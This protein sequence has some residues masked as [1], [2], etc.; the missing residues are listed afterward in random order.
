MNKLAQQIEALPITLAGRFIYRFLPYRRRLIFSNISQVYNDQLNEYQKKRLAKAYYSHLA[1]SLKEALQ[2]RFMSEKKLRAQVEVIGHEK[3]LAVVAQKKGVLVVTGHFGNWEF[4]PL[5]GVL[6]FKEF[7]G[8]FHFIRRTLRFKF[9]E[10]IMFKNYYQAGLNVIPKKN[11]LEQ[12]CVALEQNHAVIFVLD[13]HASLVNRDGIAVEFFGKKAGTYRSLATI[14]R[15]T[16]I[17]VIPAASY[18][19][20]NGKHVLEFHDPIPWK[21]YDTTQESLYR[22]TLAYNQALE[23]IIL[24]HPEQWNW[25]HKRWKL[26]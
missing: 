6:N 10:R 26:S 5:G 7:K 4:A 25:M 11:S 3:M 15:H 13:Q 22:N 8:Q 19:L 17:P 18:R 1:K 9:I 20:P 12:V 21:D 14:S 2:L 23:K 24:A 16:G